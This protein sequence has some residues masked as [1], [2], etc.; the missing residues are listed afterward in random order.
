MIFS[1][2]KAH[3]H[4][5]TPTVT[6]IT[7]VPSKFFEVI[8]LQAVPP[9]AHPTFI[10]ASGR[11]RRLWLLRPKG[12]RRWSERIRRMDSRRGQQHTTPRQV[13]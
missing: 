9:T 7:K 2:T 10:E 1:G 13:V 8:S 5:L 11:Q 12:T 4:G 3:P 6:L